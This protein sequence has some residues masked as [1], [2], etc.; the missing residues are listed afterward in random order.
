MA[1]QLLYE[2]GLQDITIEAIAE[3]SG[4]GKATIYR[5][6]PSKGMVV[7][8]A[9]LEEMAGK[10][11]VPDTGSGR[12]DFRR[13]ARAVVRFYGGK[14]GRIFAQFVAAGQTD[15]MLADA[16][17]ERFLARRRAGVRQIWDRGVARGEF[18]KD[19]DPDIALDMIYGPVI[20]RLLTK[21]AELSADFALELVDAAL[22]GLVVR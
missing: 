3:R 10:V 4:V 17:R 7:L 11:T 15:P 16:F 2:V 21:R 12:E 20:Y 5:W 1:I 22:G 18:R 9:Y 13:Q 19:I 14:E 8:D 6:W